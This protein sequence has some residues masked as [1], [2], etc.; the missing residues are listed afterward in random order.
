MALTDTPLKGT[1]HAGLKDYL[2]GIADA[3]IYPPGIAPGFVAKRLQIIAISYFFPPKKTKPL[4]LFMPHKET[5]FRMHNNEIR[6]MSNA[7]DDASINPPGLAPGV[8]C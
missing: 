1:Q 4:F 3:S 2:N 8:Y 6:P 5:L 7:V